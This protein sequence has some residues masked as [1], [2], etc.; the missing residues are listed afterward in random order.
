MNLSTTTT[1]K[2][3]KI[4]KKYI[5]AEGMSEYSEKQKKTKRKIK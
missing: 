5:D 3:T 4:K 1:R 2:F